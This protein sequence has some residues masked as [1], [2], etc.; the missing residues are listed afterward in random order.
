[1]LGELFVGVVAEGDDIDDPP[2]VALPEEVP[3]S[4]LAHDDTKNKRHKINTQLYNLLMLLITPNVSAKRGSLEPCKASI[5]LS[6][7]NSE[8]CSQYSR[9]RAPVVVLINSYVCSASL[10]ALICSIRRF[11]NFTIC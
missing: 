4:C 10:K 1:M 6:L 2:A 7:P 8:Y 9:R 5:T 3:V 11:R